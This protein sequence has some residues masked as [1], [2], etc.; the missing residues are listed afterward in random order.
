MLLIII[1]Y[2]RTERNDVKKIK[3]YLQVRIF[4]AL[5][6]RQLRPSGMKKIV[7]FPESQL[8][9]AERTYVYVTHYIRNLMQ[10]RI[11][12]STLRGVRATC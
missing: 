10:Y 11:L 7:C 2:L 3:L 1:M 9:D 12:I 6:R 4:L 5:S 8:V